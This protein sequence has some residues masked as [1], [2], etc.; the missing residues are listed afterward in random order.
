VRHIGTHK[1]L[2]K[3]RRN[4]CSFIYSYTPN[5]NNRHNITNRQT[6]SHKHTDWLRLR[7]DDR[8]DIFFPRGIAGRL[9]ETPDRCLDPTSAKVKAI[10]RADVWECSQTGKCPLPLW[11]YMVGVTKMAQS[12]V[13]VNESINS[14]I[15]KVNE[16]SRNITLPLMAA[17][18]ALRKDLGQLGCKSG[19]AWKKRLKSAEDLMVC[20]ASQGNRYKTVLNDPGRW[21]P[22]LGTAT[23]DLPLNALVT[24]CERRQ[25]P[26]LLLSARNVWA[27]PFN[28]FMKRFFKIPT[29]GCCITFGPLTDGC[30][31][32]LPIEKFRTV[33]GLVSCRV[34]ELKHADDPT[35]VRWE[36]EVQVPFVFSSGLREIGLQYDKV[37]SGPNVTIPVL[38][39]CLCWSVACRK[40]AEIEVEFDTEEICVLRRPRRAVAKPRPRPPRPPGE[41][42]PP[43]RKRRRQLPAWVDDDAAFSEDEDEGHD[44]PAGPSDGLAAVAD[45]EA[46]EEDPDDG[47]AID[48]DMPLDLEEVIGDVRNKWLPLTRPVMAEPFSVEN[49]VLTLSPPCVFGWSSL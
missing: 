20:V 5:I 40:V 21:Q 24:A 49:N 15:K 12:D 25:H 34:L 29:V 30:E 3:Q 48:P 26:Q 8:L 1:T 14:S 9:F 28:L 45:M 33:T 37:Y 19:A 36:I 27:S 17:R 13:Q 23:V 22:P 18:I 41:P 11:A 32:F 38:A 46:E 44:D 6:D 2:R 16:R 43:A 7:P 10:F 31:A 4:V 35:D 47:P 39:H 42:K